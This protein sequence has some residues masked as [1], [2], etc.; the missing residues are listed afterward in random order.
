MIQ[1]PEVR[2]L[3]DPIVPWAGPILNQ[4]RLGPYLEA[5]T[6][7]RL[8]LVKPEEVEA[9]REDVPEFARVFRRFQ[10]RL[11]ERGC[12]DYDELI[13]GAIGALCQNPKLRKRWQT[14]CQHLL[15]DEF[16]DLTPAYLLL[17][18]LLAAPGLSGLRGG[19]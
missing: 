17:L 12:A 18:R 16:Q 13:Y 10:S 11:V 6:R 15:V 1:E 8:A 2:G 19:G 14:T 7:V 9:E 5:L 4:D 3:L